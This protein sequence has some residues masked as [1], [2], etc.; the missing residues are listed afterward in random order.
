MDASQ[1]CY[2]VDDLFIRIAIGLVQ[3]KNKKN[4]LGFVLRRAVV[5][6]G[7]LTSSD[8]SKAQCFAFFKNIAKNIDVDGF[9]KTVPFFVPIFQKCSYSCLNRNLTAKL[10][11]ALCVVIIYFDG[12][13]LLHKPILFKLDIWWSGDVDIDLLA[14]Y[15]T[16]TQAQDRGIINRGKSC[17]YISVFDLTTW[18]LNQWW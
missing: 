4:D 18:I 8:A 17:L 3:K 16:K 1:W 14:E 12:Q 6:G 5:R 15:G 10:A 9:S 11:Q 2:R 13:A 7:R